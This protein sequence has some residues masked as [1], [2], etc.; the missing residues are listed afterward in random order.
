M[1]KKEV[2]KDRA[3]FNSKFLVSSLIFLK[4]LSTFLVASLKENIA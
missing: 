3:F 1:V 2:L 4:S